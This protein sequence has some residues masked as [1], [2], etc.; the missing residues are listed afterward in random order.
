MLK[1]LTIKPIVI[2]LYFQEETKVDEKQ[3]IIDEL[4]NELGQAKSDLVVVK[5]ALAKAESSLAKANLEI[6][7]LK[8]KPGANAVYI[9]QEDD[10]ELNPL[11]LSPRAK[12]S[13]HMWIFKKEWPKNFIVIYSILVHPVILV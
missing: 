12:V 8:T 13:K 1:L 4:L 7:S 10:D 9:L 3:K 5:S 6:G 2:V 11:I